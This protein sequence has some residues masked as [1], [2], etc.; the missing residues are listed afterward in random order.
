MTTLFRDPTKLI[1]LDRLTQLYNWWFMAQYLR[2]RFPWLAS[3][4]IPLSVILLDLD[5]F[6]AVNETHGRLAGDV[7]LKQVALL[8]HEGRRRGGYAVRYSGDEFFVFLEGAEGDRAMVV[9]EEIRTRVGAGPIVVP[10][11]ASGIPI[12][13]S[14]GVATFPQEV[15]T[16]SGLI[17]KVRRALAHA[18][19]Q[20]KDRS[21][22]DVGERLPTDKEALRQLHRPRLLGREKDLDLVKTLFAQAPSGRNRFVLIDGEHGVGKSRF[23]AELPGFARSAGLKFLQG[24]CLAQNRAVPYSALTP[25]IQEY[26]DRSPEL[27]APVA[28]RLAGPKLA[29]VGSVLPLLTPGK[30]QAEAISAPEHRRQLFHGILDLLCLISE[31]SPLVALLENL[32]WADEASLEVLLHLLSREDGKVIVCAT[33][34]IDRPEEAAPGPKL[35]S[36]AAFLPY[37]QASPQFHRL[38]LAPLTLVQVGDLA[39]D[40]LRHHVPARFH[41]QLFHLSRGV[42]LLVEETLKGLI[43]R[44]TLRQE[45]GAWNFEQV[46][47]EDFP[48]SADEAIAR[49]LENLDP[50]TLEVI[51]EASILGPDVDLPVLAEVLGQDPGETLHL[52][53][54]GRVSGVFEA[55]DPVADPGEIRFSNERLREIVYDGVDAAHRRQTHRKAAQVY[56]RLAS[57]G[58]DEAIGPIAYHFER[59]DDAGR[60]GFYREKLRALREWLFSAADVGEAGTGA[61][62]PGGGAGAGVGGET[63]SGGGGAAGTVKVRIL[64]ASQPLDESALPLAL[65]FIKTLTL[66]CKNMRV[67]PEGSQLVREEV[68]SATAHL[69]RL[70]EQREAVT[71]A[72]QRGALLAN[73]HAVEGKA[74]AALA[75]DL[76]RFFRE[77]GIRS[78]TFV[79]GVIETEIEEV[80][81]ILSGPPRGIPPEVAAWE[82]LLGSREIF[83]VGIFP[84]I[85]LATSGQATGG[86]Q[87]ETLLDDETM[88]LSAEA[89]RSLAAAVDNIRLYPPENELNVA[90]QEKLERQV[91][92]L[93]D[94]MPAVT[95]ALA[96]ETVVINGVRPNPKWFGITIPLL[97]KLLQEHSLTSV[98]L[99]RGVSRADLQV[100]LVQLAQ[101]GSDDPMSAANLGRM[102]EEHGITTVQLGSRFYTAARAS[103][104]GAGKPGEAGGGKTGQ[105]AGAESG[106]PGGR[107]ERTPSEE[108]RLFEQVAQWLETPAAAPDLREE[109]ITAAV[110][111]WLGSDREDLARRLW[112]RIMAG[113]A[114]PMEGTRQ[115]AAAG[116]NLLLTGANFGTQAWLRV[117]SL[118]PLEKALL[119]ETSPRAF[120]WEVRAAIEGLK[121]RLKDGDLSR[122]VGLAEGLGKGQV[123]K[124][125]QKRLLPL[126]TTAVETMAAAGVFEPLR[127][128]LKG[129]DPTRREQGKAVLAA[130][131][132]GTLQFVAGMVAQEE[133]A[134]VRKVAATLLRSLPD[135]G[136][137]LVVPQLHPPTPGEVSRRIVSV[138]DILAP[139]LG[140]DFFSLLAHPDVLVRAEFASVLS[141]VPRTAA[142]MF[143][144]RALS[145]PQPE[146]AA[147]ALEG[148]RA[149]HAKELLDA[150]VR[151]L[152]KEAP[153]DLLKACC[154]CL[155]QLKDEEA[156]D[157]LVDV[158]RQR[159]RFLGLIRGFPETVRAAAARALGELPFPEA[160]DALRAV[161]K[162]GS[163]AVRS[164]ARLELARR[165]KGREAQ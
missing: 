79:R 143:L 104:T 128:A 103:L 60:A 68:A 164:T 148:V 119:K 77:H 69:L 92:A 97:H 25:W 162:D 65:Q 91:Q 83:R 28:A 10:H 136:L 122:A 7:V 161:L 165:K 66:A 137:R 99:T 52:V 113:L 130:L 88:R 116:L 78:V 8:L 80:L 112:D 121:L 41:Q 141:R 6:K 22:R 64:E 29:A 54:R 147:G 163:L 20:G 132:E 145:E 120:Q 53:D 149:L 62:G 135:A 86:T 95:L 111:S 11:A 140:P 76:L 38:T 45:E 14:L 73:G 24:G 129:S 118:E 156:V 19:R 21:S 85:Y 124:P 146:I 154:G 35:R 117:L 84:A 138:L 90:I 75:Q 61:G 101:Q 42:P 34:M 125:D 31:A 43:I 96:E 160:E 9:A 48:A 100:L 150:I 3:E 32:D 16:A 2:E 126:A 12:K 47:P 37:F 144:R 133:D 81:K 127:A 5:D 109:E 72:E 142:V 152:R 87:E 89:F 39:A 51:S 107:A 18:K 46:T 131:G 74:V 114:A 50:D 59:S 93:L 26:F 13:A 67:F 44:G 4:K 155:G 110:D 1:F 123:G 134:E 27:I 106:G 49:R 57:P 71:L 159:P 40:I 63:G 55:P 82:E 98:T 94:R 56:E 158:L 15:Q 36:L 70:L 139:E 33:A 153:T 102:L 30:G 105:E 17:E 108:E 151:L 58:G 157:P 23:L 115:R